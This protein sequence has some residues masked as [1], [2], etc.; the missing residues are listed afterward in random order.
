MTSKLPDQ[1]KLE[2]L[3]DGL[4]GVTETLQKITSQIKT[5]LEEISKQQ[6][7]A[8]QVIFKNYENLVQGLDSKS[9]SYQR[10]IIFLTA[11]ISFCTLL[12]FIG[13]E[14]INEIMSFIFSKFI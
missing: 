9:S 3:K 12:N 10:S 13:K 6:I 11:I 5:K 4:S 2:A 14:T 8:Q 7:E 1:D